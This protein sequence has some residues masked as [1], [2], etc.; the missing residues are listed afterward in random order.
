MSC[1]TLGVRFRSL[2]RESKS[3][4]FSER[5]DARASYSR[6]GSLRPRRSPPTTSPTA[7]VIYSKA[8][9]SMATTSHFFSPQ[10]G[11][12]PYTIETLREFLAPVD[13]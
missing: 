11:C 4:S 13:G 6:V 5:Y 3:N 10:T 8:G 7:Y 2:R 1:G 12:R 9:T